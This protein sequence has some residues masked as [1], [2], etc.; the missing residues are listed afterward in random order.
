MKYILLKSIQD[1]DIPH[2]LSVH[3]L[4]E[5]SRFI[6]INEKKYFEYV[7]STEN[8][9]YYKVFCDNMLVGSVHCEIVD[10]ILYLSLLVFPDFQRKGYGTQII[11]DIINGSLPFEF[12][13]IE[14]AI[15]KTNVPSLRL[16]EKIGFIK[17]SVDGGLINY[18]YKK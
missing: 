8:V 17:T 7:T 11:N 13:A 3:L 12:D 9:F 6:D 14:I 4:P 2:L 1:P 10:R 18:R 16:F 15:D 5:I